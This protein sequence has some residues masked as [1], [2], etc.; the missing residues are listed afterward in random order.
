[1]NIFNKFSFEIFKNLNYIIF[2]FFIINFTFQAQVQDPIN[3]VKVASDI[4][5]NL[6][7]I[8]LFPSKSGIISSGKILVLENNKWNFLKKQPLLPVNLIDA[9]SK[10]SIFIS[11][12]TKN[13]ESEMFFWDGKTWEKF[14]HPLANTITDIHFD[15]KSNGIICGLGE[16]AIL[17]NNKWKF[18]TP[19]TN[20]N[21]KNVIMKKDLSI[22]ALSVG[23]G[24]FKYISKWQKIS[25]S[26]N[27]KLIK[28]FNNK[29]YSVGTDFLGVLNSDSLKIIR[30]NKELQNINAFNVIDTNQLIAVGKN[31]L[32]LNYSDNH[33]E[34]I[35]G[36]VTSN[37]NS[38]EMLNKHE[39]WIVGDNGI[40]LR[41]TKQKN[42]NNFIEKWKGFEERTLYSYSKII[43][44]G[45]GVV[46]QDFN[47][48]GKTDIFTSGLYENNH[49]YINKGNLY[50]DD[51]ATER[52]VAGKIIDEFGKRELNLGAC[53]GDFDNDDEIDIYVSSLNTKNKL[54]HN[55]GGGFF[56]DYTK[57]ANCGGNENDRTNS[58]ITGDVNNDGSLDIFICNENT[59][60]RLFLNNRAGIFN[61]VTDTVNLTSKFG[62]T[63][64]SF[65]DIDF[66][67]DIDLFVANW[68][69]KNRLYKNLLKETGKLK[70]ID[71]TD[72]ANVGG[73]S[74]TKSNGVVFAD[75]DNDADVD[76]YVTNR[77]TCNEFY[78][79][80]GKGIFTNQTE[81]YFGKD[82]LKSYGA[83]IADFD[84][85][86]YKDLYLSNVGENKF[87]KNFKGKKFIDQTELYGAMVSGYSTGL[88]T[89]D[90]DNNKN[91]DLYVANYLGTSST[92]LRNKPNLSK[93]VKLKLE[94][95]KDN[96]SAIG[97][98]IFVYKTNNF[99]SNSNLISYHEINGGSGYGSMNDLVSI[100]PCLNNERIDIK[101]IFPSGTTI[102][103]NYIL[104]GTTITIKD[105]SGYNKR[106]Y[107][108]ERFIIRHIYDPHRLFELL[109]WIFVLI[110]LFGSSYIG[111]KKYSWSIKIIIISVALVLITYYIFQHFLEFE[112]IF[113][114]SILPL[115]SIAV[116]MGFMHLLSERI[117]LKRENEIEKQILREKLSRDLHD[118]LASTLSSATIY[119]ELL[120]QSLNNN[121][122]NSWEFLNKTEILLNNAKQTITD[123]IWTIKPQPE[124]VSDFI[125]RV[126]EN[127]IHIFKEK[128][129]HFEISE[130]DINKNIYLSPIQKHNIYLII[131]ESLNNILKHSKASVVKI[132]VEQI[133]KK[134]Q[135]N[136]NDNGIGFEID[137]LN[138]KGNGLLNMAKRSKET[139]ADISIRSEIGIGT[140]IKII[141][142]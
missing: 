40:I 1:M 108:F 56:V 65:A 9:K 17:Q 8:I 121:F 132:N 62:G 128:N 87:Y 61:E 35:T 89:S 111:R 110:L 44:D 54:Y 27:V 55:M 96:A 14:Y 101:V 12:N 57:I 59:T 91:I 23:E 125:T 64:A 3:C 72:S 42:K 88:A 21:I 49:L 99:I 117:K 33:F 118:D 45:Y 58:V 109:K 60:N 28:L 46:A 19:P 95:I 43:D 114:S 93:T 104:P 116:L 18:L 81:E 26:E 5:S 86:G 47:G 41:L 113:F 105:I 127:F 136:I 4:N 69:D 76:L 25:N 11:C 15:N 29:I 129:I 48:D 79:N 112:N 31:G 7:H 119:L 123:L 34:K 106:F 103:S 122:N 13:Q 82:S 6:T 78:L 141:L 102:I 52:S 50:F 140:E 92:I 10:N 24:I 142:K 90:L 53:A 107:L 38:I 94:G 39:G 134:L 71:Y 84:N 137:K 74:F 126:R 124:N 130:V 16:I 98:K 32:I 36:N 115:T 83:V 67:G 138:R 133:N 37:L 68:S 73:N 20:R 2:I 85:D 75:I 77:K 139:D 97:A 22:W 80:N 135:F 66:D 120:K 30:K 63:G 51:E 100:I 70:F 131:K